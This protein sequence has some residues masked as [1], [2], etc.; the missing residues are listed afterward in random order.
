MG[1]FNRQVTKQLLIGMLLVAL[2]LTGVLWLTQSLRFVDW[3]VNRG[4]D[5]GAFLTLVAMLVPNFL[6]IILPIAVFTTVLFV[7]SRLGNDRELVAMRAAGVSPL[8]LAKPA[9]VVALLVT[10][11]SYGLYFSVLPASYAAFK[12]AQW[13]ARQ[14]YSR[15][16]IEEGTFTDIGNGVTIYVRERDRDGGLRGIL[17]HD[18]G[19]EG[20]PY[21]LIA[22]RGSLVY[23]PDGSRVVLINGS[24]QEVNES[25]SYLSVLYFERYSHD[26]V[27]SAHADQSTRYRD[28]RERSLLELLRADDDLTVQP[29]DVGKFKVEAHRRLTAPLAALGYPLVATVCLLAAPFRRG[30][31]APQ[32][33]VAVVTVLA[34][35]LAALGL[36]NLAARN[37]MLVP[38]LYV[39]ALA[40]IFT[41]LWVLSGAPRPLVRLSSGLMGP[42][43][44]TVGRRTA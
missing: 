25:G 36:E 22:E 42:S 11:F 35:A 33:V 30:G 21:T 26:L 13:L 15:V 23:G 39:L 10:A 34:L 27:D 8:G 20:A 1:A 19:S 41:G 5:V 12:D 43:P 44:A 7:Y 31:Q 24:R 14:D 29:H 16:L 38:L 32:T 9:I 4:L 2:I 3:I 17:V 37:L 18:S 40:P 28:A 6:V